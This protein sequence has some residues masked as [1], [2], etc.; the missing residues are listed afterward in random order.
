V[1]AG[2]LSNDDICTHD[3]SFVTGVIVEECLLASE[4]LLAT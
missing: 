2:K 4:N 1:N 3:A